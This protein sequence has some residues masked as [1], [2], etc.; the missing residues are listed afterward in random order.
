MRVRTK[1]FEK[2]L[3][4]AGLNGEQLAEKLGVVPATVTSIRSGKVVRRVNA[5]AVAS[6]LDR[7]IADLFTD[8][9]E[10]MGQDASPAQSGEA[11]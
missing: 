6:V 10:R 11:A 1:E 5:I 9:D 8:E 7:P 2:A 4:D 3:I